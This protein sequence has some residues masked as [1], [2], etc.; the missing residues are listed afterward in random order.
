MPMK[1]ITLL[2]IVATSLCVAL[3]PTA[4]AQTTPG[5]ILYSPNISLSTG[6]QNT[7]AGTVGG[8]LSTNNRKPSTASG[9]SQNKCEGVLV[10]PA[11]AEQQAQRC[12]QPKQAK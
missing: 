3:N 2:I 4:L 6:P 8:N 5:S 7:F 10:F 12:A 1:R 11:S 9:G